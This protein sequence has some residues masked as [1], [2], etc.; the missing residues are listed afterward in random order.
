MPS[1]NKFAGKYKEGLF[2]GG[3]G[4]VLGQEI[5]REKETTGDLNKDSMSGHN[6]KTVG[7][8]AEGL[9]AGSPSDKNFDL[10]SKSYAGTGNLEMKPKDM[11]DVS[12][13]P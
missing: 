9:F 3:Q 1:Q 5:D 8:K 10:H 2:V 12:N 13:Q 11:G 4:P 7:G 6:L